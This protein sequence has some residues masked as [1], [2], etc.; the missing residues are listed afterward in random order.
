MLCLGCGGHIVKPS[1]QKQR[2]RIKTARWFA[3]YST[4]RGLQSLDGE[5]L[6][7][8]KQQLKLAVKKGYSTILERFGNDVESAMHSVSA[9]Y[10]R[11]FLAIEDLLT[12]AALPNQGR[13][14]EQRHLGVGS[15]GGGAPQHSSRNVSIARVLYLHDSNPAALRAGLISAVSDDPFCIMWLGGTYGIRKFVDVFLQHKIVQ[16][17]VTF[18]DSPIHLNADAEQWHDWIRGFLAPQVSVARRAYEE[19]LRDAERSRKAQAEADARRQQQSW[20]PQRGSHPYGRSS[21]SSS[22]WRR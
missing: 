18:T 6:D 20:Q 9:G 7:K 17:V 10:D 15:Y 22:S 16:A 2:K 12:Q 19:K 14:K 4:S 1:S 3:D 5:A 8:A 21:Y 13:S 11:E